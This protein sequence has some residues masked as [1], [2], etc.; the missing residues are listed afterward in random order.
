M[1]PASGLHA[2]EDLH[3]ANGGNSSGVQVATQDRPPSGQR[4]VEDRYRSIVDN[5]KEVVFQTD[6]E[7]RWT[8]LNPAWAEITGFP[9][10][11]SIG[12]VFLEYVHPEDRQRNLEL[13][14]PLI[15]RQKDYCRHEIRYLT[16]DGGFRW[17]EV[18]ARLTL[19]PGGEVAGTS[20]TLSD[21]TERKRMEE[22]LRAAEERYRRVVES[23]SEGVWTLDPSTVTV[24]T[25]RKLAEMLGYEVD[26]I[27]GRS[28]L[29]FVDESDRPLIERQ[30][31][32]RSAGVSD[33]YE[34]KLRRRDGSELWAL[35]AASPLT[36]AAGRY[37]GSLVVVSD[38]TERR[39]AEESL[40]EAEERFRTAFEHAATGMTIAGVDG[41]FQRVNRAFCEMTG[42]TEDELLEKTSRDVTH[43]ADVALDLAEWRRLLAGETRAYH[44]EKRYVHAQGH[45]VSCAESV[46]L[47]RDGEGRPLCTIAQI[48]DIRERKRIE[49]E[50]EQLE[51]QLQ[52]S[53]RLE[54]IGQL[55]GGV[56]HDFNNLLAVILNYA[57]FVREELPAGSGLRD[58][59]EEIRR[60]AERA[61]A[62]TS[63]LLVFSRRQVI[64][65]Q[66][67]DLNDVIVETQKLLRRTLQENVELVTS[68]SPGELA[69]K[70]D[71]GQ[72]EQVLVNLAVNGRDSMPTG[73]TL[74][75]TTEQVEL[76][77]DE[78]RALGG[79]RPGR[80]G[81]L[82]VADQGVGMDEE[83][84]ARAFE[85]FF[86][87]KARG[88][89]TGL[90]LATVYGIAKQSGGQ[91]ELRSSPRRGTAVS[92][93]LPV[94]QERAHGEPRSP[95]PDAPPARGE[96][97]L[98]VEDEDAVRGL[99]RR[100]LE[101]QGYSVLEASDSEEALELAGRHTG[102]IDLLVTDVV[103]PGLSGRELAEELDRLHPTIP[104]V[105]VSGYTDDVVVRH[106]VHERQV[107]FVQKPF[108]AHTLLRAV[109]GVLEAA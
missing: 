108:K 78:A 56:A 1:A 94:A 75:I 44:R 81:R 24:F 25:N 47:V 107:S 16:K 37:T 30:E 5:L 39:R 61:A 67:L 60:A 59:V 41:R 20:G 106:G 95:H 18:W 9:V 100:I 69:V 58:D 43:P 48:Q 101:R 97:V 2:A 53:Q 74:T 109:Q 80:Y 96:T 68:L 63:Q 66:V 14:A 62:L 104:V 7:G 105:Y 55:A 35:F 73:G 17:I 45:D 15:E 79:L 38:V 50:N 46:S 34:V 6:A 88:E 77:P 57:S 27:V 82:T 51:A 87:T 90:G 92:V 3:P 10:E 26:E 76:A 72:L 22:S 52:Q 8:F 19:G 98:L 13:F 89:G 40:R 29:E 71:K 83:V 103:M 21:I 99:T 54:S 11:D 49:R 65:P 86:T 31:R 42:W 102:R 36:D 23:T 64:Q 33:H 91:V 4:A 12:Q 93:Y 28:V 70:A 32:R 84:A 85:P